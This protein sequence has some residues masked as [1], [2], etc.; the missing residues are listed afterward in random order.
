MK[1]KQTL[2]LL[3]QVR[4]KGALMIQTGAK[5]IAQGTCQQ[6]VIWT[7]DNKIPVG[8]RKFGDWGGVIVYG[9]AP[10]Q[11]GLSPGRADDR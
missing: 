1:I 10:I 9:N 7:S 2:L 4:N 5:L 6:P 3:Y 11:A 8:Q